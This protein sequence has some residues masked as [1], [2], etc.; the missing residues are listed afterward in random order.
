MDTTESKEAYASI[1]E[2]QVQFG[3]TILG[4]FLG[5]SIG[6]SYASV[7]GK[8]WIIDD[9]RFC[10]VLD[11]LGIISVGTQISSVKVRGRRWGA[12]PPVRSMVNLLRYYTLFTRLGDR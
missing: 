11:F 4:G 2:K 10:S 8:L 5:F 1:A 3:E 7:I 9:C 12:H 6:G